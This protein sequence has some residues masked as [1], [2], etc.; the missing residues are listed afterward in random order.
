VLTKALV[1]RSIHPNCWVSVCGVTL[2]APHP[3]IPDC[4][5]STPRTPPLSWDPNR[6]IWGS[7]ASPSIR[8]EFHRGSGCPAL[9]A[10]RIEFVQPA[11]RSCRGTA[12]ATTPVIL[13]L[14]QA[15][16]SP[17]KTWFCRSDFFL[18]INRF[19]FRKIKIKQRLKNEWKLEIDVTTA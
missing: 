9:P 3:M 7:R 10:C 19:Y 6:F 2:L 12:I 1:S 18:C 11:T 4:A 17:A 15:S 5:D 13:P 16:H 14:A 8:L